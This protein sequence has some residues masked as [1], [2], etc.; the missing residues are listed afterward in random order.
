MT[1]SNGTTET[2]VSKESAVAKL[3]KGWRDRGSKLPD[4]KLQKELIGEFKKLNTARN[5][6]QKV[7]DRT[8]AELAS[9]A[10]KMVSAFGDKKLDLAGNI[11]FPASRGD[12]VFYRAQGE[13]DPENI[14]KG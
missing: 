12:T 10:V 13:H 4:A 8:N 14:I 2:T 11:Y 6:A 7:L 9:H 3:I 5:D 1:D